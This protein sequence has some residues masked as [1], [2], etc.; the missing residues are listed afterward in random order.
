MD[1]FGVVE[2]EPAKTADA[3][4][5][6]KCPICGKPCTEMSPGS[7]L[8]TCPVHGTEGFEANKDNEGER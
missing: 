7:G 5:T 2:E 4:G 3:D 8:W 1:K 6:V